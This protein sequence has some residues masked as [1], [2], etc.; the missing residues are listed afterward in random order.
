MWQL[1]IAWLASLAGVGMVFFLLAQP[2]W[3]TRKQEPT[4]FTAGGLALATTG[5]G[6]LALFWFWGLKWWAVPVAA[7]LSFLATL[8]VARQS[9]KFGSRHPHEEKRNG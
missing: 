3:R 2:G 9:F 8:V 1:L 6:F 5:I 4:K 7:V